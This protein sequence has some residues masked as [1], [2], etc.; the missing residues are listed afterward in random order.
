MTESLREL[1]DPS[2]VASHFE[3]IV[4]Y[5]RDST[6]EQIAE[7]CRVAMTPVG[8]HLTCAR[9][10]VVKACIRHTLADVLAQRTLMS[11]GIHGGTIAPDSTPDALGELVKE[12][13]VGGAK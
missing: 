10:D 13:T 11:Y 5:F 9:E 7:I 1:T 4:N 6:D 8:Y 3:A 2:T 12:Q